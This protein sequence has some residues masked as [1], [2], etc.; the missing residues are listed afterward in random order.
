MPSLDDVAR[1]LERALIDV[2][3][4]IETLD[5]RAS[6]EQT[7]GRRRRQTIQMKDYL[8]LSPEVLSWTRPILTYAYTATDFFTTRHSLGQYASDSLKILADANRSVVLVDYGL[9]RCDFKCDA[10]VDLVFPM[11]EVRLWAPGK[12]L[13]VWVW[14]EQ[15]V[16]SLHQLDFRADNYLLTFVCEEG[17]EY[18]MEMHVRH[19]LT[20][21]MADSIKQRKMYI[22]PIKQTMNRKITVSGCFD[23]LQN[24]RNRVSLSGWEGLGTYGLQNLSE[25]LSHLRESPL[26]REGAHWWTAAG[27]FDD[28]IRGTHLVEQYQTLVSMVTVL[29][30]LMGSSTNMIEKLSQRVA[31]VCGDSVSSAVL[32]GCSVDKFIEQVWEV[33][34][35]VVHG[36]GDAR[37]II[38]KW[39][40]EVGSTVASKLFEIVRQTL[41]RYTL[42]S[43]TQKA[44]RGRGSMNDEFGRWLQR[45]ITKFPIRETSV[46]SADI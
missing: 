10:F 13:P 8:G 37:R 30:C 29:D 45:G 36:N 15:N 11:V 40:H 19:C 22:Y 21:W 44:A 16:D 18:E 33:R 35:S 3:D 41:V 38:D 31:G 43:T 24:D 28:A 7:T 20:L 14:Q 26:T 25:Y 32:G 39:V 4:G 9:Y 27:F 5:V 46:E 23:D 12:L 34:G 1:L 2:D 6:R 17:R 42:L